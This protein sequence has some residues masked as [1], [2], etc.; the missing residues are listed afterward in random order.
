[1]LEV[2]VLKTFTDVDAAETFSV[3][4][5]V[6]SVAEPD[7]VADNCALARAVLLDAPH[8]VGFVTIEIVKE[9]ALENGIIL[10][11]GLGFHFRL[12]ISKVRVAL[13]VAEFFLAESLEG[14]ISRDFVS[15]S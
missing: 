3:A 9:V 14:R 1:M 2:G 10:E 6:S 7:V 15:L 8:S 5:V 13:K 4:F 11:E 12:D